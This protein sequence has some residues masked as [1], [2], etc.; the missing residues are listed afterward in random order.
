MT[1]NKDVFWRPID[2]DQV[3]TPGQRVAKTAWSSIYGYVTSQHFKPVKPILTSNKKATI[4]LLK[5]LLG[6]KSILYLMPST[7]HT[8][9]QVCVFIKK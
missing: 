9:T 4:N 2:Q 8:G 5:L 7:Q 3:L 6:F 1:W